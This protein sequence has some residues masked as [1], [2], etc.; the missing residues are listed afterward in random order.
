LKN[1]PNRS[2]ITATLPRRGEGEEAGTE[3]NKKYA[4]ERPSDDNMTS[5]SINDRCQKYKGVFLNY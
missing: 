1:R 4:T 2:W 3:V 5:L